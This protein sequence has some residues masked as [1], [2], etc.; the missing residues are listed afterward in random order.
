M[1]PSAL[2]IPFH[3]VLFNIVN[4]KFQGSSILISLLR[5]NTLFVE[6]DISAISLLKVLKIYEGFLLLLQ[7]CLHIEIETLVQRILP[8]GSLVVVTGASNKN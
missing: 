7:S 8:T 2:S 3:S 1:L 5:Q 4:G 6:D